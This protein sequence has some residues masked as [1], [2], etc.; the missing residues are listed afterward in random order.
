MQRRKFISLFSGAAVASPLA[1]RAQEAQPTREIQRLS[2]Q[3]AEA[4]QENVHLQAVIDDM[5][6]RIQSRWV[7]HSHDR[8]HMD[9]RERCARLGLGDGGRDRRLASPKFRHVG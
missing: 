1:A 4:R 7:A 9:K 5:R 3:L 6:A 8:R 2:E